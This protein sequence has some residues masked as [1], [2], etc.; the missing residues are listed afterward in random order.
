MKESVIDRYLQAKVI[1]S[2]LLDIFDFS[3]ALERLLH[4]MRGKEKDM[5]EIKRIANAAKLIFVQRMLEAFTILHFIVIR[6]RHSGTRLFGYTNHAIQFD[7]ADLNIL[8][9]HHEKKIFRFDF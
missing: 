9:I 8:G 1:E 3:I 7:L 2:R 5:P 4:S 6:V